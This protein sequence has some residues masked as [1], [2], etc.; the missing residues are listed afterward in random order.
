MSVGHFENVGFKGDKAIPIIAENENI[1]KKVVKILENLEIANFVEILEKDDKYIEL[2]IKTNITDSPVNL[3]D[4]GC[5][6]AQILPIIVQS[7]LQKKIQWSLLKNLRLTY[8]RRCE[9]I[10]PVFW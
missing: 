9:Q 4:V 5:R 6:D 10:L 8:I 3:A 2:K 1:K 7:V